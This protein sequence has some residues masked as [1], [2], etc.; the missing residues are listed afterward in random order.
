MRP[1]CLSPEGNSMLNYPIRNADGTIEEREPTHG[2][3]YVGFET[4]GFGP[5]MDR[6]GLI[7]RYAGNGVF[8][9]ETDEIEM[10]YD[11]L[12]EQK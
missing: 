10:N 11:F 12:V 7:A 4:D 6:D 5:G 2:K 8:L 3:W 1:S 9:D